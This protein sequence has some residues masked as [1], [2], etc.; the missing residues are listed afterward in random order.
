MCAVIVKKNNKINL[1]GQLKLIH[2]T[3]NIDQHIMN[4]K[5]NNPPTSERYQNIIPTKTLLIFDPRSPS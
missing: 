2:R 4:P 3:P 1:R 5:L